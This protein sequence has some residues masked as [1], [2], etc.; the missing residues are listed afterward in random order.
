MV[1]KLQPCSLCNDRNLDP[2]LDSRT[3]SFHHLHYSSH[4]FFIFSPYSDENVCCSIERPEIIN[5]IIFMDQKIFIN[6]TIF[7][8]PHQCSIKSRIR[9]WYKVSVWLSVTIKNWTFVLFSVILCS[10]NR[11]FQVTF[12]SLVIISFFIIILSFSQSALIIIFCNHTHAR[13]NNLWTR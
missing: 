3:R 12:V 4:S 10:S 2:I 11:I 1:L 13:D 9:R 7:A 6:T 8:A 5:W